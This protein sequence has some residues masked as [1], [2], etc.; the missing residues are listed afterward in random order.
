[1]PPVT[2]EVGLRCSG[3]IADGQEVLRFFFPVS[4]GAELPGERELKNAG[5]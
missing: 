4:L 5:K 1:M 3:L 2:L